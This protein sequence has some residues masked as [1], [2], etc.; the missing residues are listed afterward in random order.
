MNI[1]SFFNYPDQPEHPPAPELVLLSAWTN[2]EWDKFLALTQ[3]LRY[4]ANEY[5]FQHGEDE[6]SFYL[7]AAGRF[8]ILLPRGEDLTRLS[9]VELGAILGED[10]FLDG[11]PRATSVRAIT[12]GELVRFS[13]DAYEVLAAKEPDLARQLVWDLARIVSLRHRQSISAI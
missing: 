6:R 10:S 4:S 1:S 2:H 3:T 8:E 11:Q 12:D 7:V 9:L 5:A 13:Q